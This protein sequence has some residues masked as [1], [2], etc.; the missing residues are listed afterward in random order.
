MPCLPCGARCAR[1]VVVLCTVRHC[2]AVAVAVARQ[3]CAT[4]QLQAVCMAVE[5]QPVRA[6]VHGS[7][8][9]SPLCSAEVDSI[10][11]SVL[12]TVAAS[13]QTQ[14]ALLQMDR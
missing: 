1:L 5:L 14:R 7:R 13:M 6:W 9:V 10:P 12:C 11:R 4:K 8:Q 3:V 2:P